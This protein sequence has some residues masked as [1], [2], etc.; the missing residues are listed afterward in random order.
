MCPEK[1]P[2][3]YAT[4][5]H[6][7]HDDRLDIVSERSGY[8]GVH[9]FP[10]FDESEQDKEQ[11]FFTHYQRRQLV[12]ALIRWLQT[13]DAFT[14]CEYS[15][16]KLDIKPAIDYTKMPYMR[17]MMKHLGEAYP[18]ILEL[19][20]SMETNRKEICNKIEDIMIRDTV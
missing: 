9:I 12:N 3:K 14:S 2:F 20:T 17:Y 1:S 11:G 19:I 6:C 8:N 7:S 15:D 5:S 13:P 10:K 16:G 4:P 18:P